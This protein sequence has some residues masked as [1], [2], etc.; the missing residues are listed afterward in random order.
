VNENITATTAIGVQKDGNTSTDNTIF[1]QNRKPTNRMQMLQQQKEQQIRKQ[2]Q[3]QEEQRQD[4]NDNDRNSSNSNNNKNTI[5]SSSSLLQGGQSPW[6]MAREQQKQ[7]SNTNGGV[8]WNV[9]TNNVYNA[10]EKD[11]KLL[12]SPSVLSWN[13]GCIVDIRMS[14]FVTPTN[15]IGPGDLV[16]ADTTSS[17]NAGIVEPLPNE[18]I[19]YERH[20]ALV[21]NNPES[22]KIIVP[23]TTIRTTTPT[24]NHIM[25]EESRLPPF[26]SDTSKQEQASPIK[27]TTTTAKNRRKKITINID[28]SMVQSTLTR[29]RLGRYDTKSTFGWLLRIY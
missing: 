28:D 12:S 2:Q 8:P 26:G 15:L 10:K 4:I 18:R 19:M 25:D 27:T 1:L 13:D 14:N 29:V 17:S 11:H 3:Q 20:A 6:V 24:D 5:D 23:K 21:N 7:Q 9:N 22:S 16:N